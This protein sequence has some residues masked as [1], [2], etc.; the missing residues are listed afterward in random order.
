MTTTLETRE[1][2]L[3]SELWSGVGSYGAHSPGEHLAALFAA[4]VPSRDL[5]APKATVLDAGCG[6]GKGGLALTRL[7]FDV[8]LCD[9]TPDGL[10]AEAQALR[11]A[12][13]CLWRD[14]KSQLPYCAGAYDF[15]YCCDVLEHIPPEYTMLVLDQLL[16]VT[17]RAAFFNISLVPDVYGAFVGKPLHQSVFPFTWWRDRLAGFGEMVECRDL[18]NSGVYLVRPR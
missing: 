5:S 4:L 7:G 8:T 1:R 2:D 15:V 14:L 9:I 3:Y 18:L 13:A 17:K 11:F 16:R 10:T 6:S 12:P